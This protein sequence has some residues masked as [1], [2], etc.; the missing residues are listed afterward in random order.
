MA[1]LPRVLWLLWLQGWNEAP[2]VAR[3]CLESWRRLNPAWEVRAIDGPGVAQYLSPPVFAQI[4]AVPKEPEAF[5]D[6]IRI[7]L[8]HAHGG[9]WADATA[10]CATPLDHRLPQRMRTGFFAFARPTPDRI[11]ASWF[12]A[13]AVPCNIVAKWRASV[14]AYWTEREYRDDYFWFHKLFGTLYDED[15]SFRSDW[16]ATPSLPARHAFHFAPEDSRLTEA[17]TPDQR[18]ALASPPSPVFKLTH[19]IST[20]TAANSLL[21][22][23]CDFGSGELNV[24]QEQQSQNRGVPG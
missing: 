24:Q 11:I 1:S 23:L 7:E 6:Q 3:A 21:Q 2:L 12:L 17:A 16:D 9:V 22:L 15:Q 19:K 8:L 5:A 10:M 4:A 13:A 20:S 14:A 18:A